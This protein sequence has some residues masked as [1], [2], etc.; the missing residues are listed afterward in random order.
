MTYTFDP[1]HMSA[2]LVALS[3]GAS[4]FFAS[5]SAARLERLAANLRNAVANAKSGGSNRFA[6]KT[7][8]PIE[9]SESKAWK[10]DTEDYDPLHASFS[11]DYS[12]SYV[13]DSGRIVANGAAIVAICD[14]GG[15]LE[16]V[17]HFDVEEGGWTEVRDGKP[18]ERS[19]HPPFHEQT[20]GA[21]NDIPRVPSFI[22]HPIDVLNFAILELHQ[23]HWRKHVTT[24]EGKSMLRDIPKRQRVR[25]ATA[26][27]NWTRIVKDEGFHP[28]VSMQR[29]FHS[30]LAL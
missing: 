4:G 14:T 21:V 9:I 2:D 29:P 3:R 13:A 22:V 16:K 17:I 30:P 18:F 26:L 15:Q 25:L 5:Q 8:K 12:C 11:L 27:E 7:D 28:F 6:W 10:G 23:K 19:G 24:V 1:A 20:K